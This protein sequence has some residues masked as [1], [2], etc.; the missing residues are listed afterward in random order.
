V[1]S[2]SGSA[3]VLEALGANIALTPQQTG[4]AIDKLGLG[5][6]FARRAP[7]GDESTPR[8]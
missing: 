1:S 7:F 3:E 5:F 2:S 6:M 4:Q 8:R